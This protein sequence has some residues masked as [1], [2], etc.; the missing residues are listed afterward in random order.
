MRRLRLLRHTQSDRRVPRMGDHDC[1]LN[2]PG[3]AAAPRVRACMASHGLM[4]ELG[5]CSTATRT[6][7]TFLLVP[8]AIGGCPKV[9]YDE[10]IYQ[11][12]PGML[13][14]IVRSARSGDTLLLIGHN[15]S[16]QMFA[17]L[18]VASGHGD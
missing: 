10:R 3:R 1:R 18:M 5:L 13:M 15:P 9:R 14:E 11:N 16:F 7:V 2:R 12:D 6:R 17:E 4:P 8:T